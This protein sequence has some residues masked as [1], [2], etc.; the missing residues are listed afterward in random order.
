MSKLTEQLVAGAAAMWKEATGKD[1]REFT[2]TPENIGV[3]R[4]AIAREKVAVLQDY[5]DAPL[6]EKAAALQAVDHHGTSCAIV[7]LGLDLLEKMASDDPATDAE[8]DALYEEHKADAITSG[9][10]MMARDLFERSVKDPNLNKQ[11]PVEQ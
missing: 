1:F 8:V 11:S 2:P 9:Q 5:V 10:P 6:Y 4:Q 3:L 7:E